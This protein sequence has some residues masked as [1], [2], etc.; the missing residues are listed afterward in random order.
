MTF[1]GD[2]TAIGP[3]T[4]N[5]NSSLTTGGT[6]TN[7]DTFTITAGTISTPLFLNRAQANI[8]GSSA[9]FGS[10]TNEAGATTTIR[11]GTLFVFGSLTN[12]GTI[13]GTICSNC[14]GTPPN[15]DIGGDLNL[16]PAA[17]LTMP[18]EGSTVRVGGHFN[19]AIN[20]NTRYDMSLATLQMEGMGSEQTLEVMSADIGADALGLDRTIA[21][22]YPIDTLHIGASPSTVRLVDAHDNDNLGQ[23]SCEA[24][25]V[26]TLLIDS[27]SRLINTTC[28]IYYNTLISSGTVDVPGNLVPLTPAVPCDY[29]FNQDE[30]VDLLDAQ[31]MA[32]VFVGLITPEATWLDGD[33][34]GDENADLTDAQILAAYVVSGNCGV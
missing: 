2:A 6:F 21:G 31:Q 22:H 11:S 10:Y 8:F 7:I 13:I 29:D 25:Y 27:G 9:V 16:G 24:I 19:C 30:N 12:N 23:G 3:T 33:L 20:S 34:N 1:A 17:N 18:F 26:D 28:R 5:L 4:A 32:Q 15:M 14:L